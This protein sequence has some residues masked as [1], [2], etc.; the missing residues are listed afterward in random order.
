MTDEKLT[1]P[2]RADLKAL[3]DKVEAALS[4]LQKALTAIGES[5]DVNGSC[6]ACPGPGGE[7]CSSLSPLR[8][9]SGTS[10]G[11]RS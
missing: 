2:Q 5:G 11:T 1:E 10:V 8:G 6:L 7:I 4:E 9:A 3:P